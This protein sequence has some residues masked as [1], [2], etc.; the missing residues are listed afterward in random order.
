[1]PL[2]NTKS[3]YLNLCGNSIANY[4]HMKKYQSHITQMFLSGNHKAKNSTIIYYVYIMDHEKISYKN[5]IQELSVQY[6]IIS[7]YQRKIGIFMHQFTGSWQPASTAQ[8]LLITIPEWTQSYLALT[9]QSSLASPM[10]V[11]LQECTH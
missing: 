6:T 9:A 5:L 2:L 10:C 11:W 8:S 7:H 1:M 4:K 3:F